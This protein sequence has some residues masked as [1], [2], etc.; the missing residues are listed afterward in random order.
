MR[1]KMYCHYCG[2]QMEKGFQYC[3]VCG[4]KAATSPKIESKENN[5]PGSKAPKKPM[6]FWFKLTVF[7][8]LLGLVVVTALIMHSESLVDVVNHQLEAFRKDDINK[9]YSYTAK[10]FQ[11]ATSLNQF[12]NFI[13]SYPVFLN[14]QSAHF[15]KRSFAENVVTL[16]GNMTTTERVNVPIEYK[17]TKEGDKWK[18]LSIRLLKPNLIPHAKG[19]GTTQDLIDVATDLLTKIR[20]GKVSVVYL[21]YASEEF[22]KA[23]TEHDFIEF[24]KEYPILEKFETI[25]FPKAVVRNGVGSLGAIVKDT[26]NEAYVK[27]YLIN[28]EQ[29]WKILSM[30]ILSPAEESI[31]EPMT[32][33]DL[34]VG[35]KTDDQ[36]LIL[37]SE[38]AFKPDLKDLYINLDVENGLKGEEVNLNLLHVESGSTIPIK[39]KIAESGDTMLVSTFSPPQKGWL[40]GEYKLT[41]STTSGLN[42]SVEFTIE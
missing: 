12:K 22:K 8:L 9:A 6:P 37:H 1:E 41:T 42:K 21:K 15:T 24:I 4:T 40:K 11:S 31:E 5:Q 20:E 36:G 3:P 16:R 10:D 18:I 19:L 34:T 23:T 2:A 38:T 35:A 33:G 39:A 14:N 17:L 26:D 28:E 7:V 13:Q 29:T 30:R 32:F 25:S 27:F